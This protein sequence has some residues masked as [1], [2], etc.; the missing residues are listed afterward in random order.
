MDWTR[1]NQPEGQ[2]NR[3]SSS[4]NIW[5]KIWG[6]HNPPKQIHLIW[7]IFHNALPIKPN[8]I[9]RGILCD[10]L[11][12]RCHNGPETMEHIFL[13][14]EWA[15]KAW[16]YSPLTINTNFIKEQNLCEWYTHMLTTIDG[17][18]IQAITSIIYSLWHA[19]NHKVFQGKEI[20]VKITVDK[21]LQNLHE[22]KKH[23]SKRSLNHHASPISNIRHNI[24]GW[25]P[26][27]LAYLKLNVIAHLSDEGRLGLG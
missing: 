11:C 13:H 23:S 10:N 25:S 21:A 2:S 6:L 12:P 7:R 17:E 4:D 22:Y 18:Y 15:H 1:N 9:S 16:F 3:Q 24:N 20:P 19:R 5:K 14:C 8:L 26:S 27:P